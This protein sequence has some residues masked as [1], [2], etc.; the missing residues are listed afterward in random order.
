MIVPAPL[1]NAC[2]IDNNKIYA[3]GFKKLLS[4]KDLSNQVTHFENGSDAI[5]HL[6]N[7]GNALNL[8]DI[9]F[10]DLSMPVMDG[11]EFM[12]EFE[13]IKSQLGKKISVYILSSSI[14]SHDIDRAKNIPS[15]SGYI[16]KP[17]DI[18]R[19]QEIFKNLQGI[20]RQ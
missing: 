9:I 15:V 5:A 16:F 7:P 3:Y 19:L 11:W 13:E 12:K 18:Q 10:L 1:V 2:I 6:R 20:A 4:I 17:V 8:P 14:D